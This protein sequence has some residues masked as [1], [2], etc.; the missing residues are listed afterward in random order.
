MKFFTSAFFWARSTSLMTLTALF[1]HSNSS[2]HH[3][4]IAI[5]F[6]ISCT[7]SKYRRGSQLKQQIFPCKKRSVTQNTKM[8]ALNVINDI[9][10]DF[11]P[12]KLVSLPYTIQLSLII[13]VH[14]QIHLTTIIYTSSYHFSMQKRSV[15]QNM[16]WVRSTSS[17][18]LSAFFCHS[19]SS[20][21]NIRSAVTFHHILHIYQIYIYDLTINFFLFG[22]IFC[23]AA[24]IMQPWLWAQ[25]IAAKK[26][27]KI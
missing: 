4:R 21:H 12:F 24:F 3:I 26:M 1:C 18:T 9:E 19:N 10:R 17:M 7:F 23:F 25:C 11:L 13:I 27:C 5:P 16:K 14:F 6:I 22:H 15:S 8:G 20:H 2:H